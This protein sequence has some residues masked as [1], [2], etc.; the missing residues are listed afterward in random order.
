V[1]EVK[2]ENEFSGKSKNNKKPLYEAI[3]GDYVN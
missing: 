3:C 2:I 1:Q